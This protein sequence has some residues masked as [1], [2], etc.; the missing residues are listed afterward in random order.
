MKH[1][2]NL[3]DDWCTNH[4]G[5]VRKAHCHCCSQVHGQDPI[6]DPKLTYTQA[7][8]A[9][10]A[11]PAS[12][13][14]TRQPSRRPSLSPMSQAGAFRQ[15]ELKQ[16]LQR[17]GTVSGRRSIQR[18]FSVFSASVKRPF[19]RD[20]DSSSAAAAAAI[21]DMKQ[22][23]QEQQLSMMEVGAASILQGGRS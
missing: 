14:V 6:L 21:R 8:K 3:K 7:R 17:S 20:Q 12:S 19:G 1:C 5:S 11:Q 23:A 16:G 2:C 22:W 15:P 18:S 13:P 10:A 4:T 9:A